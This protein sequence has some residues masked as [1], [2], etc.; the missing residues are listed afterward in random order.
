MG[1]ALLELD[2]L[3]LRKHCEKDWLQTT[4]YIPPGRDCFNLF[5]RLQFFKQVNYQDLNNCPHLC[6]YSSHSLWMF[7]PFE[8][9][10]LMDHLL[11]LSPNKISSE[12]VS[13]L[14]LNTMKNHVNQPTTMKTNKK[15]YCPVS[16]YNFIRESYSELQ[17]NT[18]KNQKPR[19]PITNYEN[20]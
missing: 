20:R 4:M 5:M 3:R 19:K 15:N 9:L 12:T 7:H 6:R 14:K 17:P 18:M 11:F 10:V 16:H 8:T 13:E 2:L 1:G